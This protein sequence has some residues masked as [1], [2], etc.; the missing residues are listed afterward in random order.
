[1]A[2]HSQLLDRCVVN[3]T[4]IYSHLSDKSDARRLF[5][6]QSTASTAACNDSPTAI[7]LPFA[8]IRIPAKKTVT[9]QYIYRDM[10]ESYSIYFKMY[11]VHE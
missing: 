5:G 2:A 6:F 8:V 1:M 10:D 11:L 4:R 3:D 9:I 7:A